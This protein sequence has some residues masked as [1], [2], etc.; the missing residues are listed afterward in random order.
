MAGIECTTHKLPSG[1][2]RDMQAETGHDQFHNHDYQ[3]LR[4]MGFLTVRS[5]VR[6][7]RVEARPGRHDFASALPL[8]R[9]A[10]EAGI[11][12]IWDL[13]H[14]GWP[15]DV[16]IFAPEFVRRFAAYA[17]AFA[18]LYRQESD[19]P[20][21][22]CPVNEPSFFSWAGGDTAHINPYERGRGLELKVQLI[23]AAIE[24]I[25]AVW[26]EL[27]GARIVTV[28]PIVNIVPHPARPWKRDEALGYHNAQYQAF[29]M[30]TGRIWPQ[31]GGDEKYLDI[32]GVNYYPYNQWVY[33]GR[34]ISRDDPLYT[35]FRDI[36]MRVYERYHKPL[37]IAETGT[38]DDE[39]PGWLEYV[40][41]EAVAALDL[42]IPLH[43]VCLYPIFNHP[44]WADY[45]HCRNGLWDYCDDCGERE[46]YEPLAEVIRACAPALDEAVRRWEPCGER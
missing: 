25:E 24:G 46:V 44:G 43:G 5:G 31:L 39:R 14:F 28:D 37:L 36:L 18:R 42:G 11:Q 27:P 6:W 41:N 13:C 4:D 23:R 20:L 16:D 1:V 17:R 8:M 40:C 19:E 3:R 7:H 35:P 9:G 21:F 12:V 45:R 33:E 30:L 38:E 15:D 22:V 26:S 10:A 34:T 29:D 32:V 2:R